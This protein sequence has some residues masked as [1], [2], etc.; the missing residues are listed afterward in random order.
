MIISVFLICTSLTLVML[1]IFSCA[2]WPFVYLCRNVNSNSFI[3]FKSS[4]VFRSLIH[5]KLIFVNLGISKG[6]NFLFFFLHINVQFSQQYL[7]KSLFPPTEW[8][9]HP[10]QKSFDH[11]CKS[12]FWALYFIPSVYIYVFMPIPYCFEYHTVASTEFWNHEI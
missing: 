6:S 4:F 5:F 10:S 11:I 2:Y 1:S 7:L 9:W 12:L 8:S 3:H